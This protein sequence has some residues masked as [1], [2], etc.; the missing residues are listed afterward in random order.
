M[1]PTELDPSGGDFVWRDG[2][3]MIAF[4]PSAF[5]SLPAYLRAAGMEQFVLLATERSIGQAAEVAAM[6]G[7]TR[8]AR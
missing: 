4:G 7:E 8:F 1:T 3:R 6:A 2:E 5:A